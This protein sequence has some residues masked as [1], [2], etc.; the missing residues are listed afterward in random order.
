MNV[1]YRL[2]T[3]NALANYHEPRVKHTVLFYSGVLSESK[4]PVLKEL[5]APVSYLLGG[6][7]D[8]AFAQVK[9]DLVP[10]GP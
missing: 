4:L 5:K 7:K 3:E 6:P 9:N 2:Y 8:I 1:V 10:S